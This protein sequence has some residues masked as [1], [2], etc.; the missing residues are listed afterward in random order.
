MEIEITKDGQ[1]MKLTL[2]GLKGKHVKSLLKAMMDLESSSSPKED[3]TNYL[4]KIDEIA[5]KISNLTME[6]LDDLDIEDKEKITKYVSDKVNN[7]LGFLN[8]SVK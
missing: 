8:P 6:E 2:K 7:S 5:C 4:N 1:V 3:L